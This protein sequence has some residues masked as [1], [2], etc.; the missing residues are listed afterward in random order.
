M[1]EMKHPDFNTNSAWCTLWNRGNRI[2]QLLNWCTNVDL[3]IPTLHGQGCKQ[4]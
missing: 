1:L 4:V 2:M 3:T